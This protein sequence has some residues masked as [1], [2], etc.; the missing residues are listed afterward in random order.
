MRDS[1]IG[2]SANPLTT[3][4]S[5]KKLLVGTGIGWVAMTNRV[6]FGSAAITGACVAA[7]AAAGACVAAGAWLADDDASSSPSEPQAKAA[8]AKTEA[9]TRIHRGCLNKDIKCSLQNLLY[10]A[11]W[12]MAWI[13][14][15]II[16]KTVYLIY[17]L[18]WVVNS[19]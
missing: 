11:S 3:L 7:G 5:F 17:L 14:P 8:S 6:T 15:L 12:A 2:L 18:P 10:R 13:H 1:N 19:T 9:A 4:P 16:K